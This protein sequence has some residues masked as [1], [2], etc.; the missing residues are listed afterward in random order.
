QVVSNDTP[1]HLKA[2]YTDHDFDITVATPVY[3]SD[4]AISTTILFESGLP[5]GV[6]VS[7]QYG[8]ANADVDKLIKD[9]ASTVD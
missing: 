1:A 2:V 5:T 9:A 4:P 6:P 8:Y 7:N 3:R